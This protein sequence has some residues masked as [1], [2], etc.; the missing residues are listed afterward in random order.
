MAEGN[1]KRE[2][3]LLIWSDDN[4]SPPGTDEVHDAFRAG[5]DAA[6]ADNAERARELETALSSANAT[7]V[8]NA[9]DYGL[10]LAEARATIEAQA[11]SLSVATDAIDRLRVVIDEAFGAQPV[12]GADDALTFL[13]QR[14]FADRQGREADRATIERVRKALSEVAAG[15]ERTSLALDEAESK[16]DVQGV[17]RCSARKAALEQLLE[18]LR[19]ALKPV[20]P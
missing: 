9:K 1:Q 15:H 3:A 5:Y 12:M 19:E 20:K 11:H 17:L 8:S 6:T 4:V 7:I 18:S 10:E 2:G 13:E 14:L 16:Q